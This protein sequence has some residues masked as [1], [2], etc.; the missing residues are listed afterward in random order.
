MLG[1]CNSSTLGGGAAAVIRVAEGI[2]CTS[3]GTAIDGELT[4]TSLD[5]SITSH[6][7]TVV[8]GDVGITIEGDT[9]LGTIAD[10]GVGG[11][12]LTVDLDIDSVCGIREVTQY[13]EDTIHGTVDVH[14]KRIREKIDGVSDK[15]ELRTVWGVGYKF[16]TKG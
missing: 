11:I 10:C 1:H 9:R 4:G 16:E 7:G 2:S 8:D 12:N 6:R 15:W 5:T 3:D 14:V 13:E